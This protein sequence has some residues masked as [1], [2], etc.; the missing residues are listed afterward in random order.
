MTGASAV[1]V[2][3]Y[4]HV[5]PH[6]GLVTVSPSTFEAQMRHLARAGYTTLS[7]D[8][9]ADFL[10]GESAVPRKSVLI[11]FDDG[12][13]DN[14]VHAFPVLERLGL[15]AVIFAVT[16][17]IG[18]GPARAHAGSG[19]TLPDCPNHRACMESI[20]A[21]RRDEVMLRWSEIEAMRAAGTF[22]FHSHSHTHTRWDKLVADPA[23]RRGLLRDDLAASRAAL[24]ERLGGASCHLCWPQGYY[25]A[26]YQ[27][28][29]AALGF[30]H[31]YTV[32][33]G[34]NTP[35]TSPAAINRIVVKDKAGAWFATRLGLY[36][37]PGL[38][39]L[40]AKLRGE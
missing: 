30:T 27:A 1:P 28:V 26:D 40:Y 16:G 22:E 25:D 10:R 13:L 36:R 5:S 38:G 17:W 3:M 18:D 6:P 23:A 7:A 12:Y 39:G 4:H 15:H 11:T 32:R 37:H 20:A 8:R 29:A 14:Y 33:K 9:F 21:G 2:L 34:V 19:E 31:L 35:G 24:A